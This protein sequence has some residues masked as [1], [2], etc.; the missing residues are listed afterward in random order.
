MRAKTSS[1]QRRVI[2]KTIFSTKLH[3]DNYF[4]EMIDLQKHYYTIGT[5]KRSKPLCEI[6]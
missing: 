3:D 4:I 2:E 6:D 1:E 5:I